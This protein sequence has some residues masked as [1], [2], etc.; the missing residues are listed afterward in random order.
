MRFN[1]IFKPLYEQN[2]GLE[3]FINFWLR[4]SRNNPEQAM[5]AV[6]KIVGKVPAEYRRSL[7]KQN[8]RATVIPARSAFQLTRGKSVKTPVREYSSWATRKAAAQFTAAEEAGMAAVLYQ[9][10]IDPSSI[11]INI[12]LAARENRLAQMLQEIIVQSNEDMTTIHP[13]EVTAI[14]FMPED[15]SRMSRQDF[16]YLG[17]HG[18]VTV[19][20][21]A[22]Y[23]GEPQEGPA[24]Q[25][26]REASP[27]ARLKDLPSTSYGY[28][29]SANGQIHPVPRSMTHNDWLQ[30]NLGLQGDILANMNMAFSKGWVRTIDANPKEFTAMYGAG[31]SKLALRTLQAIIDWEAGMSR[32]QRSHVLDLFDL[33]HFQQHNQP[34]HI[35]TFDA[36]K[37]MATVQ[38]Y[39]QGA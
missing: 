38:R 1:E 15:Y 24:F 11:V 19:P 30:K 26:I 27:A 13:E 28:W 29:I 35:G 4:D 18:N 33:N 37:A 25:I 17:T 36:Q 22:G 32:L 16:R 39:I 31:A 3:E 6:K 12:T 5:G 34:K 2:S 20:F 9:K 14:S 21:K 7:P 10:Q 23:P 8:Y